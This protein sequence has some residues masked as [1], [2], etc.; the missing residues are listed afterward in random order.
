MSKLSDF[1]EFSP[2]DNKVSSDFLKDIPNIVIEPDG[3]IDK[4]KAFWDK[5]FVEYSIDQYDNTIRAIGEVLIDSNKH[6]ILFIGTSGSGKTTFLNYLVKYKDEYFKNNI[7]IDLI[8]LI[9]DPSCAGIGPEIIHD[10]LDEKIVQYLNREVVA[11]IARYYVLYQGREES[12][13]IKWLLGKDPVKYD[14]HDVFYNFIRYNRS[15][16]SIN[17]VREFCR[18]I[19]NISDKMA[20]YIISFIM[21][22]CIDGQK[23]CFFIFDNLDELDQEYLIETLNMD[24]LSAFSKAQDFFE[25]IVTNLSYPFLSKCTILESIRHNFVATVNSTQFIEREERCSETIKFASGYKQNIR[26]IIEKRALLHISANQERIIERNLEFA[27][28]YNISIIEKEEDY[29]LHLCRL[30][31]LDYRTTLSSLSYALDIDILSWA[32]DAEDDKDCRLGVRGFLLYNILKYR[33]RKPNTRLEKYVK[34]DLSRNS[35]CNRYRMCFSILSKMYEDNKERTK[36]REKTRLFHV[37]LLEFTDRIKEWY[38]TITVSSIYEALFVSGYHNYSLPANLEGETINNYIRD[39][40]YNV[41]LQSLCNH[42]TKQYES[43]KDSL[44]NVDIVVNPLCMEYAKHVF[45]HFEYFNLLSAYQKDSEEY[46]LKTKSLFQYETL[47]EIMECTKRVFTITGEIIRKADDHLCAMCRRECND[48]T[49]DCSIVIKKTQEHGFLIQDNILYTT[50]V[51]TSHINY[52][53]SFRK[54]LWNTYHDT[55]KKKNS[56]MQKYLLSLI[57]DYVGLFRNKIVKNESANA[58]F[59][60]IEENLGYAN[61]NGHNVWTPISIGVSYN[62]NED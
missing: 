53:D 52:L 14:K 35:N 30:F 62:S 32:K 8:N 11:E 24:I 10:S 47:D 38:E 37:S 61:N 36:D 44:R 27:K 12:W 17:E 59:K 1:L 46:S 26:T 49:K 15:N 55:D 42:L 39:K 28:K 23:P 57:K 45:I 41:T 2:F 21:N 9:K 33:L 29:I 3:R 56:D 16:Y 50:R 7:Q 54:L 22:K 34:E 31:N 43:D 6:Y 13:N 58:V 48:G 18:A 25:K 40:K 60:T 4:E 20:L 51:I 19:D 5:F